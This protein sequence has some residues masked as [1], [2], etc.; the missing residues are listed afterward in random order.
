M[1]PPLARARP[2]RYLSTTIKIVPQREPCTERRQAVCTDVFSR[3]GRVHGVT[4]VI[5]CVI[6]IAC[7]IAVD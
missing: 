6:L 3:Y 7:V 1:R 4:A 2:A 5:A